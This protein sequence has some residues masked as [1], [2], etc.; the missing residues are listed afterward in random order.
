MAEDLQ[1]TRRLKV[2]QNIKSYLKSW[3]SRTSTVTGAPANTGRSQVR[4]ALRVWDRQTAQEAKDTR[5]FGPTETVHLFP[6]WAVRRYVDDDRNKFDLHVHVSGYAA[7]QAAQRSLS[8]RAFQRLA[9]GYAG[10]NKLA[11]SHNP[12]FPP[13]D[14]RGSD[15]PKDDEPLQELKEAYELTLESSDVEALE[16]P[17]IGEE[18]LDPSSN[19]LRISDFRRRWEANIEKRIQI[20]LGNSMLSSRAVDLELFVSSHHDVA[21]GSCSA[22]TKKQEGLHFVS[23]HELVTGTDGSFHHEFVINWDDICHHSVGHYSYGQQVK[24][25]ELVLHAGLSP[26]NLESERSREGRMEVQVIPITHAPIRVISDIDDTIK[27]SNI[28]GGARAIFRNVFVH[29]LEEITIPGMSEWYTKMWEEGV[30]FHYVS[31]GPLQMLPLIKAFLQA[32]KLPSGSIR[33]KSY[34]AR[35]IFNDLLTPPADRKRDGLD[36]VLK[37]FPDSKFI[38]IGDSGEQDLELYAQIAKIYPGQILA[39]FVRDVEPETDPIADATGK[40]WKRHVMPRNNSEGYISGG[41]L[42]RSN[43]VFSSV[44]RPVRQKSRTSSVHDLPT[45]PISRSATIDDAFRPQ[46]HSPGTSSIS[47][48]VLEPEQMI[49]GGHFNMNVSSSSPPSVSPLSEADIESGPILMRTKHGEN[50]MRGRKAENSPYKAPEEAEKRKS[51][52]MFLGEESAISQSPEAVS[53]LKA[54]MNP[55]VYDSPKPSHKSF[56]TRASSTS[57][58]TRGAA[59]N[60]PPSRSRLPTMDNAPTSRLLYRRRNTTGYPSDSSSPLTSPSIVSLTSKFRMSESEK[61]RVELQERVWRARAETPEHVLL[62][63]FKHPTECIEV[64]NMLKNGEF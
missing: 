8:Q 7:A 47:P 31:N 9:K 63:I 60:R 26:S 11:E 51:A 32:S 43:S 22:Y 57:S 15:E 46:D 34:G 35:S 14:P 2:M 24:E 58:A 19:E 20:V 25:H 38:L 48:A 6:G 44:F 41:V 64:D 5:S 1:A 53:V 56:V 27:F 21:T 30:R 37:S 28:L 29:D 4:G 40:E 12:R 54:N 10:L 45:P 59:R 50:G 17:Y 16:L 49:G 61:K 62:R 18:S 36:K 55:V 39:I 13:P 23:R 52:I 33:L 42:S 3:R